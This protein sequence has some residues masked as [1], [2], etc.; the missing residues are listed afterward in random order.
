MPKI[1]PKIINAAPTKSFYMIKNLTN[2]LYEN[3]GQ[4]ELDVKLVE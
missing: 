2:A 3:T 1:I 4:S